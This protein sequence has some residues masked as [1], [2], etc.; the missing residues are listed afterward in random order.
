MTVRVYGSDSVN[1]QL[2]WCGFS[3]HSGLG[4]IIFFR[5]RRFMMVVEVFKGWLSGSG[6]VRSKRVI[7]R[8]SGQGL[9]R[10]QHPVNS[11]QPQ[12]KQVNVGQPVNCRVNWSNGRCGKV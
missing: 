8:C 9:G 10:V 5:Q 6:S 4:H 11:G 12:S 3:L 7:F 1:D 2:F